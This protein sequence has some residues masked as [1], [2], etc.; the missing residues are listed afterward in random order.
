MKL[1]I[2]F[3][4]G[5]DSTFTIFKALKNG[6]EIK[7][8]ITVR[9][10]KE[11][12]YMFHSVTLEITKIQAE[13][14]NL[15]HLYVDVSGEKEKEVFELLEK[16]REISKEIDGIGIGGIKSKYQFE[17]FKFVADK[18]GKFLYIPLFNIKCEEYW[19]E[20]LKNNFKIILTSVNAY[21]LEKQFLAK[22]IDEEILE[23]LK[24]RSKKYGFDL[25]FEGGEAETLVLDCPLFSKSIEIEEYEILE[26]KLS[27]KIL[28]KKI[29]LREK[30]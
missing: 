20:L 13:L 24:E 16:L 15:N 30:I 5:K 14:M 18:L 12:S 9:P 17:R 19:N 28:I 6:H 21:G 1:A 11:D 22:V 23:E 26:E 27:A 4:G 7:Y 3:T 25:C 10:K 2:F 29:K 8:L